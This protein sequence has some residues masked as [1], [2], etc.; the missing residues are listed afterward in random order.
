MAKMPRGQR[1]RDDILRAATRLFAVHGYFHTSTEDILQ[2]VSISKGA[3]Y[4]HFN[5]KQDM[6]SAA[7]RRVRSDYEEMLVAPVRAVSLPSARLAEML[8]QVVTLNQSGQWNNFLLLARLTQETAQQEGELAELVTQ[9]VQWLLDFCVELIADGQDASAVRTDLDPKAFAELI[10]SALFG[11]VELGEM[12]DDVA[13]LPRV[14]RQIALLMQVY[15]KDIQ[16]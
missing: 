15:P 4:H 1:T 14:A 10:V 3:F 7:L 5:S 9:T 16:Q 6:A 12:S 11:A 2:A 13:V 8:R